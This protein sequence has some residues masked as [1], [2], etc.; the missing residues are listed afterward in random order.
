MLCRNFRKNMNWVAEANKL[1]A[2]LMKVPINFWQN[3]YLFDKK[4]II[5]LVKKDGGGPQVKDEC[6]GCIAADVVQWW[7]GHCD[8]GWTTVRG[9][10]VVKEVASAIKQLIVGKGREMNP[11]VELEEW[12]LRKDVWINKSLPNYLLSKASVVCTKRLGSL[13]KKVNCQN[14]TL[15]PTQC[16]LGWRYTQS[17]P[18]HHHP[19]L[20]SNFQTS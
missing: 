5:F 9:A 17:L 13:R 16:N 4:N 14:P 2:C 3:S 8:P 20:F 11:G 15:S 19:N 1:F 18:T 12:L 6:R 7:Q 10:L